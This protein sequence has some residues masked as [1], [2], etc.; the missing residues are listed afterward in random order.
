MLGRL[1][2]SLDAQFTLLGLQDR[3]GYDIH[4]AQHT[5]EFVAAV[6]ALVG[7]LLCSTA[8]WAFRSREYMQVAEH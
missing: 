8:R 2:E 1:R 7:A 6:L 5:T 4:V 3:I